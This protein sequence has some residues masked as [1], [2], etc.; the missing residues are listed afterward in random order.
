MILE[1]DFVAGI[2]LYMWEIHPD[3]LCPNPQ[4]LDRPE[5]SCQEQTH[6]DEDIKIL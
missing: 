1:Q 6:Y 2:F 4:T 5:I 3:R